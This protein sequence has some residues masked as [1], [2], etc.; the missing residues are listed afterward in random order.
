VGVPAKGSGIA[1]DPGSPQHAIT[2]G[3][4]IQFTTDGGLTWKPSI[5]PPPG[6]GPYLPLAVSPFDGNVWFFTHQGKL[7]KTR[8]ASAN[9]RDVG[10]LPALSSPIITPGPV[11]EFFLATENKVFDLIDLVDG[12]AQVVDQPALANGVTLVALASTGGGPASLVARDANGAVYT[13]QGTQWRTMTTYLS[14]PV[15]AGG[16][17]VILIGDGRAKLGAGAQ[18]AISF[19]F[20]GGTIWR[21]ASGL[22]YD[23]SVEAIAGLPS[24]TTFFAYCYGGDVYVSSNSGRDWAV[25]S[26]AL[27]S[28]T[29]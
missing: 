4:T 17:G 7:L 1:I 19:S 16:N 5:V 24:S 15:A 8:D 6:S 10:G 25:M 12:G 28:S 27:R 9:W 2:G 11:G 29:G 3:A 22:P 14:G 20:D 23:Q 13:L 18:G 21:P 26:K